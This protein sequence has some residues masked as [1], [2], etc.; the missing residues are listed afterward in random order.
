MGEGVESFARREGKSLKRPIPT[1]ITCFDLGF[2]TPRDVELLEGVES[3]QD[4][5]TGDTSEDIGTSALHHGHEALVLHD[6]HGAVDGA[7]VLDGGSGGHHHTTTNGVNGVGHQTGSDGH[8]VAQAEGKE[9]PS[10]GTEEDGL[11]RVVETEVHSTVNENADARDD[12]S[13]VQTL[14]TVG[15]DGLGVDIDET[16]V[17]ALT[18][19]ALGVVSETGT[20]VIEGV[21]E[22]QGQ[23]SGASSGQNVGAELLGVSSVFGDVEGGLYFV[24]EGEVE[25][26]RREITQAVGQVTSPQ[27]VNALVLD[28]P[29]GAVDD[30]LVGLVETP[31][32]DHLILILDEQLDAL[33]GGG[34][35]LGH[36]GG[37]AGKGEILGESQL[38]A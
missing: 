13:T 24:L 7:L 5:G 12:E 31:L 34:G 38:L 4:T 37:N 6:L 26:L 35:R 11:Q 19:L 36:D 2:E 25:G 33:D 18:A 32:T 8:T 3:G 10:I 29:G 21:D 9:Q 20:G 27:R 28:G 15:L 30:A 23:G 17:L 16:L 1:W 14:D 22:E